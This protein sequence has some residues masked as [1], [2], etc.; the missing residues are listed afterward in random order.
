MRTLLALLGL[1]ILILGALGMAVVEGRLRPAAVPRATRPA[2]P[3]L[4]EGRTA[5]PTEEGLVETVETPPPSPAFSPVPASPSPTP[6]GTPGE[7]PMP[8]LS[9]TPTGTG[10]PRAPCRPPADWIP[11]RVQPGDTAYRLATLAGI[12]V[13]RFLEANCLRHPA[14]FIG[15]RVYLPVRRPTPTPNPTPC[16]PPA[17]WVLYTVQPGET[18]Y[19]LSVR[20]GVP[21][22]D[23]MQAN[24]LTT[25]SLS[26]GQ[27]LYVPP[28]PTPTGTPDVTPMPSP[29]PTAP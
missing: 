7:A 18:L 3:S 19:R 2:A 21:L 16:G 17:D 13:S 1:G 22:S 25:L 4:P 20:F 10:T 23:L 26:A 14:L 5:T 6:S 8:T 9:V 11:Y 12:S 29:T 28:S 24:C 15:Q 27:R